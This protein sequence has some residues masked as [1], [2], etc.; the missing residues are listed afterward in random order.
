MFLDESAFDVEEDVPS[1]SLGAPKPSYGHSA[2]N[3]NLSI[4]LDDEM[5]ELSL[6]G[7]GLGSAGGIGTSSASRA[8]M[9]AQQREINMKKRQSSAQSGM[10]RSSVD[11]PLD[12]SKGQFTPTVRQFSAPKT[13]L[14]TESS[15]DFGRPQIKTH[16][17]PKRPDREAEED[18]GRSGGSYGRREKRDDRARR[19][20][21]RG[22]DDYEGRDDVPEGRRRDRDRD[23]GWDDRDRNRDRGGRRRRDDDGDDDYYEAPRGGDR[24]RGGSRP[25]S[26]ERAPRY[27]DDDDDRR[28]GRRGGSNSRRRG[29]RNR[30]Y[31]SGE[32][33]YYPPSSRGGGRSRSPK[34]RAG[35]RARSRDPSPH[36]DRSRGEG[37]SRQQRKDGRGGR[38]GEYE[39]DYEG[40]Q[41]SRERDGGRRS[42][43]RDGGWRGGRDME[44]DGDGERSDYDSEGEERWNSAGAGEARGMVGPGNS[45]GGEG[46][47][48]RILGVGSLTPAV[49]LDLSD[50]TRFLMRPLPRGAG[51][52]QCQIVR[53]KSGTHK[54]FPVYSLY[55]KENDRFLMCSKKRPNNKTSNYL[56]SKGENDLSRESPNFLGK[57]RSNF[58][59]TEFQVFDNG[60]SPK[61]GDDDPYKAGEVR[62]ELGAV[63]YAPNV[64]GSRGPRKMQVCI[65]AVDESNSIVTW[66][67]Q[68]GSD[69]EML[70]RMKDRNFRDLC[71][72]INKPPR[73]NEQ[74]GAYV[75]NFS[76][77]VTM[78]SVKNFQLVDPDE[79]NA[80]ILQFG[81][82][83]KDQFTMDMQWPMSPFQAFAITLSSFDSKIACD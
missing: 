79:Q 24:E 15:S 25:R 72:F 31:S 83:G 9:L 46:R 12:S 33:D 56:I 22:R 42:R 48:E 4:A 50:M 14:Q 73:W 5:E 62:R 82:V 16:F 29:D 28:G 41:R 40:S 52:V 77:R 70:Q 23:R 2:Q 36:D 34:P 11:S 66:R 68:K 55:L 18:V 38:R 32:E 69:G 78:A 1:S 6:G 10:V 76:G 37:R 13:V 67:Q 51:I 17:S 20:G 53:N 3:N 57:L 45:R 43:E 44:R 27:H 54:L 64:L 49:E 61:E 80:V 71:Y 30:D 74:V 39:D 65:P 26:R 59:G 63:M 35:R 75:L 81:R 58:V 7:S 60:A 47:T 21:S 19:G 8:R